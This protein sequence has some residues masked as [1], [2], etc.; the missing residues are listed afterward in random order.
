MDVV[1]I[2]AGMGIAEEDGVNL[3]I[4]EVAAVI[5]VRAGKNMSIIVKVMSGAITIL[6]I[7]G[8]TAV[9]GLVIESSNCNFSPSF[10]S[11]LE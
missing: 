2:L 6:D 11:L 10:L 9:V 5:V 4:V 8:M 7:M 3:T 1:E